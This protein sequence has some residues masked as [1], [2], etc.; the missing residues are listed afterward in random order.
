MGSRN[1]S[2]GHSQTDPDLRRGV[3]TAGG[4]TEP[5]TPRRGWTDQPLGPLAADLAAAFFDVSTC[6]LLLTA[7]DG[8]VVAAN[9]LARDLA[10]SGAALDDRSCCELFGCRDADGP[11]EGAC[12]TERTLADGHLRDLALKLPAGGSAHAA[13]VTTSVVGDDHVLFEFQPMDARS[14]PGPRTPASG[15]LAALTLG[16]TRLED[17]RGSLGGEWL[18]HRP[19]QLLKLLITE[20]HRV[21]HVDEIIDALWGNTPHASPGNVRQCVYAIRSR[22]DPHRRRRD[23]SSV[24]IAHRGGYSIDRRRLRV[25]CDEFETHVRRGMGAFRAND[26]A[27]AREELVAG[28]DLYRGEFLADEPYAQWALTER[29]RL[30]GVAGRGLRVLASIAVGRHDYDEATRH[31]ERLATIDEYDVDVQR[32]LIAMCLARGRRSEAKRRYMALRS[33]LKHEFGEEP[34]FD[35]ADTGLLRRQLGEMLSI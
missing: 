14:G 2:E 1:W 32:S 4:T 23:T 27:R 25:D 35:L 21:V 19:G 7:A 15:R 24:I 31:L 20:R 34:G 16:R 18:E 28:L 13:L 22:L 17:D 30:A 3:A 29:S 5:A 10:A 6:G 33:R 8:V 9:P 26:T 12:V 11:L